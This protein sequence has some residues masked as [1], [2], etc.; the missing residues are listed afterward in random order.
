M[1]R[2]PVRAGNRQTNRQFI[3]L[4]AVFSSHVLSICKI[5]HL[6]LKHRIIISKSRLNQSTSY[7][8]LRLNYYLFFGFC[9]IPCFFY[10]S[11]IN[12]PFAL[13]FSLFFN[14][15][16]P[17][18][19]NYFLKNTKDNRFSGKTKRGS[20]HGM[21]TGLFPRALWSPPTILKKQRIR[22]KYLPQY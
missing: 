3:H 13:I 15:S 22:R 1:R 19:T 10:K 11:S 18:S 20:S 12:L 8:F 7:Y 9:H 5:S 2:H 6:T 21:N 17:I 14:Y 16:Q 4:S